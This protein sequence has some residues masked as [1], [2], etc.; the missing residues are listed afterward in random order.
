MEA[1]ALF[2][3]SYLRNVKTGFIGICYANRYKQS[4]GTKVDLS[5]KN[6]RRDVIE[7]SVKEAIEITLTAIKKMYDEDLV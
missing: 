2:V 7:N 5:V 1:S 6:P 3:I 4:A